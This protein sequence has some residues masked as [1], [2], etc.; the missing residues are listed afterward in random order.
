M[1]LGNFQCRRVLLIWLIV[2]QEPTVLVV[3]ADGFM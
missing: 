3:G 1:V 2:G